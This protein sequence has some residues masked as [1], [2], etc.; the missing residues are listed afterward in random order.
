MSA[1]PGFYFD[2]DKN[3]YFRGQPKGVK[4]GQSFA[5]RKFSYLFINWF[6]FDITNSRIFG[7]DASPE[8]EIFCCD[9]NVVALVDEYTHFSLKDILE[10]FFI[11]E[12]I[13]L[14]YRRSWVDRDNI[15]AT[16]GDDVE[17]MNSA[18]TLV[19]LNKT[20]HIFE[21]LA[22]DATITE[23]HLV[24]ITNTDLIISVSGKWSFKLQ[25]RP[26]RISIRDDGLIV[27]SM[28]ANQLLLLDQ[29]GIPFKNLKL[30][31][32]INLGLSFFKRDQLIYAGL[33]G[34]Y[35]Y[36]L[37]REIKSKLLSKDDIHG[38][39]SCFST[40]ANEEFCFSVSNGRFFLYSNNVIMTFNLS[41]PWPQLVW[42]LDC[43][44]R[45]VFL[46]HDKI[47]VSPV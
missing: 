40:G 5:K 36:N 6:Y 35:L 8:F 12:H 20:K 37:I 32:L 19:K 42:M 29:N 38:L 30:D 24:F 14:R 27:V 25:L 46:T 31:C 1:L 17:S 18:R 28:M 33:E 3:R 9:K 47:F 15:V 34:I 21:C 43:K 22:L 11:E 44:I 23:K 41:C 13:S 10:Q 2:A 39:F 16:F 4:R 7:T 26:L 45:E